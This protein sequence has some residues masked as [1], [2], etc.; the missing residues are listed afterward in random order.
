MPGRD[1]S[2]RSAPLLAVK[3]KS[4]GIIK[5]FPVPRLRLPSGI[6]SFPPSQITPSSSKVPKRDYEIRFRSSP[7]W[8]TKIGA[9]VEHPMVRCTVMRPDFNL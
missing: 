1:P 8:L 6:T 5:V 4:M 3:N 2:K 7:S 9:S